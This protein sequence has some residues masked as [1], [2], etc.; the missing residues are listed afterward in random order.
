[1]TS[2]LYFPNRTGFQI[3]SFFDKKTAGPGRFSFHQPEMT[4]RKGGYAVQDMAL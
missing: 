3:Q 2:I 1:M 4:V